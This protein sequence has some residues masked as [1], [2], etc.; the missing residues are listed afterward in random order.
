MRLPRFSISSVLAVIAILAVALAA[1][2][3]PS[4]LWANVTF[5]LALGALVVGIINLIYGRNA[6]RAYWVGF[7]L[8]GG[9]YLAICSLPGLR[10]SVCPR[11]AT[12]V[13]FDLLYPYLSPAANPSGSTI[14]VTTDHP[15]G[16]A[17][18]LRTANVTH[19]VSWT[20]AVPPQV[21]STSPWSAWTA[22]DRTVG[23]GYQI[24]TITLVP[25]RI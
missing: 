23:D 8:C 16:R 14:I 25:R 11:L 13:V 24:G 7:S 20:L 2:R 18:T 1:L 4:Y 17:R 21:A 15:V 3:S 10:D 6:G 12:E 5:S 9:I 22:P 19:N